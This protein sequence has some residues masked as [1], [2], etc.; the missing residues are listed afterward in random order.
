[1]G[2]LERVLEQKRDEVERNK[3]RRPAVTM[4]DDME[5]TPVRDFRA[6]VCGGNGL[7]RPII[8]ELKART[9]SIERFAWSDRLDELAAV[10]RDAGAAAISVVTDERNFGTTLEVARRARAETGLPILVKDF[11]IDPYQVFEARAHGADAVLLIARLLDWDR[12]TGLLDLAAE[13]QM[14]ALVE[15]HDESDVKTA[16]QARAALVGVNH[17]DL[18]TLSVSADTTVRL[19]HLVPDGVVLVAESGIRSAGDVDRLARAG[20]HAFLV[21]GALLDSDDPGAKLKE[22]RGE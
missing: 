5:A 4:I 8:A 10:Y 2:F 13:L 21:G 11:V 1:M 17:R 14:H 15:A 7:G 3:R 22:L 18:D 19:S 20:A 6:A 9:P 12:L 16:L